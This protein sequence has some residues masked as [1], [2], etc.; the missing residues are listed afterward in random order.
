MTSRSPVPSVLFRIAA[1]GCFLCHGVIALQNSDVY[2]SEWNVWVQSLLP[3]A[4]V[5]VAKY[6]LRTVGTIDILVA[7]GFLLPRIPLFVFI[8]AIGWGCATATSRLFFL[9]SFDG[10]SWSNVVRPVAETAARTANWVVPLLLYRR[11]RI[12]GPRLFAALTES[13]WIYVAVLG[14][15]AA[16][17]LHYLVDLNGPIYPLEVL[18]KGEPLWFF[19]LLGAISA[20]ALAALAARLRPAP[21]L[22]ATS[23]ALAEGF[24]IFILNSPHGALFTLLR[25][26]EHFPIYF[27]FCYLLAAWRPLVDQSRTQ[28]M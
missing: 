12:K 19:H 27:C 6:F 23:L 1:V 10:S 11:V 16:I 8:W 3:W 2:F 17:F 24:E 28:T 13:Q 20:I 4:D 7:A 15:T 22:A 5:S 21:V 14:A 25:I 18:R 9:G 26:G